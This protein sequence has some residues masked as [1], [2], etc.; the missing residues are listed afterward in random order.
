M[1]RTTTGK[2]LRR[3]LG[4]R[5]GELTARRI[6]GMRDALCVP[7]QHPQSNVADFYRRRGAE[8]GGQREAAVKRLDVRRASELSER[9]AA[10]RWLIDGLW[11]RVGGRHHRRRAQVLQVLPRPR[12]GRQRR[13]RRALPRALSGPGA[14]ARAP[15]RGRGCAGD[16]P[17]AAPGSAPRDRRQLFLPV[18]DN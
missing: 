6:E 16:R 3:S 11:G 18:S 14:R 10:E 15:L 2:P 7:L 8:A 12:D 13:R 5:I 9:R 1:I 4:E 17:I